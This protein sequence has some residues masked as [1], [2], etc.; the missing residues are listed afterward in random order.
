MRDHSAPDR[1]LQL[2]SLASLSN[3]SLSRLSHVLTRLSRR[4]YLHRHLLAANGRITVATLTDA[5]YAT[6]VAPAPQ[7][8]RT[9]R[10]LVFDELTPAQVGQL[11]RILQRVTAQI[12]RR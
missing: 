4:G 5:G 10:D 12:E 1:T 2:K 7:H 6:V 3:G 11:A 8:V 9:V